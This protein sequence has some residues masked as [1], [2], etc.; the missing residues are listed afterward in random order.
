MLQ[1]LFR[2]VVCQSLAEFVE[3][4]DLAGVSF[5][6]FQR[7]GERVDCSLVVFDLRRRRLDAKEAHEEYS[8]PEFHGGNLVTHWVFQPFE[9]IKRCFYKFRNGETGW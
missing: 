1:R 8:Q 4:V 5:R 9:K 3:Q 2:V 6:G 7:V